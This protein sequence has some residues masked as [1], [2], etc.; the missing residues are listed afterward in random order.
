[1]KE[2]KD[3]LAQAADI[4][5]QVRSDVVY[6][7]RSSGALHYLGKGRIEPT[8]VSPVSPLLAGMVLAAIHPHDAR[9]KQGIEIVKHMTQIEAIF[10]QAEVYML[11]QVTRYGYYVLN[12]YIEPLGVE[13]Y[14]KVS[15][16]FP[17][18]A[19]WKKTDHRTRDFYYLGLM[20][21]P[22]CDAGAFFWERRNN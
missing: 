6:D 18:W 21:I 22:A 3:A 17:V 8:T 12:A 9:V 15:P 4:V 16:M 13:F 10:P 19:D 1:M 5:R 11:E 14:K 2:V 7:S 20:D